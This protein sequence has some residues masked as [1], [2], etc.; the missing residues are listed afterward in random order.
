WG[1]YLNYVLPR[2]EAERDDRRFAAE[3]RRRAPS[4]DQVFFFRVEAHTLAF[5]VGP[6]LDTLLAWEN[7]DFWASLPATFSVVSPPELV[8]EWPQRL[9]RG[10][11]EEVLSN[12]DLAGGKPR[13]PLVLM[14]PR[15]DLV[16]TASDHEE[17]R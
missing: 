6:R 9:K 7:L 15:P 3:I 16:A 1:I 11:L 2:D 14:R 12:T 10:R 13:H 4:P 17:H 8:A 5:H